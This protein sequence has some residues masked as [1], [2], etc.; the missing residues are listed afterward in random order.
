MSDDACPPKADLHT[1]RPPEWL[2]QM[3]EP[4]LRSLVY[5]NNQ[6]TIWAR[7]KGHNLQLKE[8]DPRYRQLLEQSDM[9]VPLQSKVC[10]DTRLHRQ[11]LRP[12]GWELTKYHVG[13]GY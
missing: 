1:S 10:G 13:Y 3:E 2:H 5:L 6:K 8:C 11:G 9:L 4:N 12:L 7:C